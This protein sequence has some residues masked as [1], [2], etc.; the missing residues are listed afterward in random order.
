MR[1]SLGSWLNLYVVS[2]LILSLIGGIS[3]A[4]LP[5]SGK[6]PQERTVREKAEYHYKLATGFIYERRP[7]A[8]LKEVGVTLS[9]DPTHAKAHYLK[10]FIYMGRRN[11]AEAEVHFH[12][13]IKLNPKLF[14][15]RNALAGT[16]IALNRWQDA[17]DALE[18]LLVDPINP[19]PWL[20]H[21][22][23]GW[24]H[25][26][27]GNRREGVYH[28][29]MAV[30]LKPEFCLGY[31]NLGR[32]HKSHRRYDQARRRFEQARR[33]CPNHAP[34]L[35]EL[36]DIYLATSDHGKARDVFKDCVKIAGETLVGD[37]CAN[38]RKAL[39]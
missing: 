7:I 14:E 13:A 18:P 37:R 21:N 11:Y 1:R 29:K 20:A 5:S 34:T 23:A 8:A 24:A 30:M 35:L 33:K 16:Y 19:T 38:R 28:L 27:M 17:V 3:C 31:Y 22:N 12:R 36:G 39:P 6:K 25:H 32:V 26:K 15:A 4:S 2:A 9:Y 10:G